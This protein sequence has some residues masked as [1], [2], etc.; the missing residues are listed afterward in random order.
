MASAEEKVNQ[1]NK[2]DSVI[3]SGIPNDADIMNPRPKKFTLERWT[4]KGVESREYEVY[5][6]PLKKLSILTELGNVNPNN[7]DPKALDALYPIIAMAIHEKDIAFIE[8]T[9]TTQK[10]YELFQIMAELNY[11]G[12]PSAHPSLKKKINRNGGRG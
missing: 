5:P 9:I 2:L 8:D 7:F 11:N 10:L 4:D 1:I 3:D 12:I 6:V